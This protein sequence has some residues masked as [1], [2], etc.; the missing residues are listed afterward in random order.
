MGGRYGSG[1]AGTY[2]LTLKYGPRE[3]A[4]YNFTIEPLNLSLCTVEVKN[5]AFTGHSEAAAKPVVKD[6]NGVTIPMDDYDYVSDMGVNAGDSYC[7]TVMPFDGEDQNVCGVQTANFAIEPV[8]LDANNITW[9]LDPEAFLVTDVDPFEPQVTGVLNAGSA[10]S[11]PYTLV[12]GEDYIV[13]YASYAL[14]SQ[15]S[16]IITAGTSGNFTSA[17]T[18]MIP[19]A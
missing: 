19:I 14:L 15:A 5:I 17:N 16:A 7:V 6:Q 12:P 9:T 11:A 8:S 18:L 13:K 10:E 1:K 4:G 3:F 2:S